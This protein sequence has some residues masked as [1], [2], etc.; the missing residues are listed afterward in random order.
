M[1]VID[2]VKLRLL[3]IPNNIAVF[4]KLFDFSLSLN[5]NAKTLAFVYNP[6]TK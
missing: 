4:L 3:S 2:Y 5:K 1:C 6:G